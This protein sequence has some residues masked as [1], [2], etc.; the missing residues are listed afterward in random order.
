MGP[1][2]TEAAKNRHTEPARLASEL[3]G[4]LDWI[5]M[6]A[7]EKDRTRRYDTASDLAADLGRHLDDHPVLAGPPSALYRTRKFVRRH[8]L[9][10]AAALLA[11]VA[12]AGVAVVMSV[13]AQRIARERDRAVAAEKTATQVSSFMVDLFRISDPTG[14]RG[15]TVT[16]REILDRGAARVSRDLQAQ[17]V[18]Q[19]RL[20]DTLGRVYDSLGLFD[21]AQPLL[22]TSLATRRKLLGGEDIEVASSLV[23]NATL[24]FHKGE[25]GKAQPM[26]EQALALH[27]R[28]LGP[29]DPAVAACLH[30]LG[31]VHLARGSYDEA[32]RLMERALAIREK[33]LPPDAPDTATT[34]NSLGAIA[35][36]K[37]DLPKAR[38]LWERT[39]AMRE[40]TLGPEHP[41]VAQTLNNLG[42]V[43]TYSGD[44]AGARPLL[45]R[46][47]R[48]QEK[49]L[50]PKHPDLAFALSNLGDV[51]LAVR[52]FPHAREC[53]QRAVAILEVANPNHPEIGRFLSGLAQASLE[54]GD[55]AGARQSCQRCLDIREKAFGKDHAEAAIGLF[56]LANCDRRERRYASAE[57]LFDRG[58]AL[59]RKPDGQYNVEAAQYLS[60]Y[61]ALLRDM[62]RAPR[63][64]EIESISRALREKTK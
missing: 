42:I 32:Q 5:T 35:Y 8:R 47:I 36:R 19:A 6:K 15:S 54:L 27:Q 18:V 22:E 43:H 59:V 4:D 28:L 61:A 14:A 51:L 40:R 16:A 56:C 1:A 44:A 50:G 41:N 9:G 55:N 26:L 11:V 37:G 3:R 64:A 31:N 63:A 52:D 34:V 39:L 45:E 10:V 17:P 12:L 58:L 2:S 25:F 20:M 23:G 24:W 48:I 13:Q 60:D 46:V 29:D 57:A 53:Y 62:G 33:T 49:T 21:Q 7:L 38:R 30:N